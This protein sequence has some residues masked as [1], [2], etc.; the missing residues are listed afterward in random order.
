MLERLFQFVIYLIVTGLI[1]WLLL[2]LISYV[3]LVEPFNKIARVVV[4]GVGVIILIYALMSL[5]GIGVPL[6]RMP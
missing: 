1:V 6:G 3:N 5:A 4:V 2:W